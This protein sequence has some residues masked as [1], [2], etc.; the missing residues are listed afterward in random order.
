MVAQHKRKEVCS[1][2]WISV[3]WP[4]ERRSNERRL[5]LEQKQPPRGVWSGQPKN[6]NGLQ[7]NPMEHKKVIITMVI[8]TI[9]FAAL[10]LLGLAKVDPVTAQWIGFA[11]ITAALF[12]FFWGLLGTLLLSHRV[13]RRK[14]RP[15][16][17]SL[18]QATFFSLLIVLA[19]YLQRFELLT[20][21]N[22]GLLV[23]IAVLLEVFFISREE[24]EV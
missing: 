21:W 14:N 19:L 15:L 17:I 23:T 12:L 2:E 5:L 22:V 24:L 7:Q 11:A 3:P 20:W 10:L 8:S 6:M 18:R 9:V 16:A 1:W 4:G 13:W